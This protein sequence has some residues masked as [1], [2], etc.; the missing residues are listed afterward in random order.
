MQNVLLR[1]LH[2]CC[3]YW[4]NRRALLLCVAYH[5]NWKSFQAFFFFFKTPNV[6]YSERYSVCKKWSLNWSIIKICTVFWPIW[7]MNKRTS[8]KHYEKHMEQ[9][10]NADFGSVSICLF[11]L[12]WSFFSFSPLNCLLGLSEKLILYS[13]VIGRRQWH[14]TPVLLP[15]KSHGRR[16]LVGCSPWGR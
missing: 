6:F 4:R 3:F 16:S 2:F 8:N 12:W 11:I 5:F 10:T 1:C 13:S 7:T 9:K 15:G 14:P